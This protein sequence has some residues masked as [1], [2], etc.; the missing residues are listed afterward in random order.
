MTNDRMDRTLAWLELRNDAVFGK[1]PA[2]KYRYYLDGALAAGERAAA[3]YTGQNMRQLCDA[4][5]IEIRSEPGEG[6]FFSVQFRAQ[7]EYSKEKSLR[8][9]TL[10]QASLQSLQQG[11]ESAGYAMT[12][13]EI[14]DIHLAHEFFH[15][16][17][18]SHDQPVSAQLEKVC[19]I[20]FGPFKR[21]SSVAATSE[22]AAHRFCQQLIGLDTFPTWFDYLWLEQC[23]KLTRA[24]REEIVAAA[25]AEMEALI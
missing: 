7:F 13:E 18:Y 1:I 17:E 11:C 19:N 2:D 4:N 14:T 16:L 21:Y 25:Q 15:F 23:G 12:L 9:I 8:R 3:R 22:I 10:Y 5:D 20:A 6:L 24:Q